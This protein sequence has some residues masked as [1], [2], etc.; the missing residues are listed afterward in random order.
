MEEVTDLG[1]EGEKGSHGQRAALGNL[2]EQ[3]R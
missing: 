1:D 3:H 2:W